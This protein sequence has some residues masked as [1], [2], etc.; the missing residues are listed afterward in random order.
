MGQDREKEQHE[1]EVV[2]VLGA[3]GGGGKTSCACAVHA[4]D[5]SYRADREGR[6]ERRGEEGLLLLVLRWSD[7]RRPPF[8]GL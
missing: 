2:A 7:C 1:V 4:Q 5:R 8:A 3:G 6:G